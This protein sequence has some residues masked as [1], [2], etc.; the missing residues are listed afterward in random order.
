MIAGIVVRLPY[1]SHPVCLPI[2]FRLWAGKGAAS[3]VELAAAMLTVLAETFP[4]KQIHAV[5]DAAYHGRP[6]LVPDTTITTR[7]PANA[8]LHAPAPP[9]TGRRGRP[10]KKG[11]R[12]PRLIELPA[13]AT[14]RT[15]TVNRYGRTDTIA[16]AEADCLWYGA[17]G[18][19]TGRVVLAREP[20][21]ASGYDLAVF[22]TGRRHRRRR[23]HR[24][25]RR[26]TLVRPEV[27]T[28][29]RR[30]ARQASPHPDRRPI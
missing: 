16:I 30:H 28:R 19:T 29:L 6:L 15:A 17:F 7:L 2:L 14:W 5:G 22:T 12:L 3:P 25:P 4:H 13:T 27:R 11:R 1:C 20:D 18:D 8:A 10:A 23:H 26:R 9:R 24:P 21:T